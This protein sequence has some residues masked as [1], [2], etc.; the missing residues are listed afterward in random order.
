MAAS[1]HIS[2]AMETEKRNSSSDSPNA[3]SNEKHDIE[4]AA[5][6]YDNAGIEDGTFDEV[7]RAREIQDR[8]GVLRN[9]RKAEEW[10]DS[11]VG[12]E[13]QGIDRIPDEAKQPPSLWNIFLLWWS[14]NVHVGV[15]PLG[16][17]GAEFGLSLQQ[18]VAASIVGTILGASCTSFTGTLGPKVGF[19]L[20]A[21][22]MDLPIT[23]ML[24]WTQTARITTNRLLS[25]LLRF[26]G[27]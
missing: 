1:F 4:A 17:L 22:G 27:C 15:I 21:L 18:T 9:L 3:Y 2:V 16:L 20:F 14:L 26:L 24:I 25:I 19:L 13:M 7:R 12:I 5:P 6:P 11:K 8:T 23:H 10:L